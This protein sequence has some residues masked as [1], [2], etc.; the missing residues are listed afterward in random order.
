[1]IHLEQLQEIN[2]MKLKKKTNTWEYW[3]YN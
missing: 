1:M 2:D 3:C